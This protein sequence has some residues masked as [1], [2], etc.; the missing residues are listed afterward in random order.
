[1]S[2]GPGLSPQP[3][4]QDTA[5][6][7]VTSVMLGTVLTLSPLPPVPR[8]CAALPGPSGQGPPSPTSKHSITM[9]QNPLVRCLREQTPLVLLPFM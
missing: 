6:T 3:W 7:F 8:S 5:V 1:M 9:L 4:C 2:T